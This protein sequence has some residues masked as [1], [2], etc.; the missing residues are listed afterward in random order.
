MIQRSSNGTAGNVLYNTAELKITLMLITGRGTPDCDVLLINI[1]T[2]YGIDLFRMV[3]KRFRIY[4]AAFMF[5]GLNIWASGFFTELNNGA[6]S[7]AIFLDC[8]FVF[9]LEVVLILSFFED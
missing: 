1:F 6:V 3:S 4:A 5:I 8:T 2:S 7:A 9:Q